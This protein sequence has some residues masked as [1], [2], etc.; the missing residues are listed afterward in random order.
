M[1]PRGP[2]PAGCGHD[3]PGGDPLRVVIA[4]DSVILREGLARHPGRRGLRSVHRRRPRRAAGLHRGAASRRRH[5]GRP[6]A[7]DAHHEGIRAAIESP[8][9]PRHPAAA[10]QPVH[11]DH[12]SDRLLR[13]GSSGFGYLLK[14]RVLDVDD[15]IAAVRRVAGG[16]TAIDPL[17]VSALVGANQPPELLTSLSPRPRRVAADGRGTHQFRHL[18]PAAHGPQDSGNPRQ[19]RL[20]QAAP[21]PHPGRPSPGAAVLTYLRNDS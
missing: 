15:F 8:P 7:T 5:C 19:R 9:W 3:C 20:H 12:E 17:I 11:R 14:D 1:T 16:G 13:S 2:E 4:E 21:R 18:Q 10:V 6:Y